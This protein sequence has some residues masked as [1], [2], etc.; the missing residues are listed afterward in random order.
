MSRCP[1]GKGYTVEEQVTDEARFGGIQI[2][3]YNAREALFPEDDPQAVERRLKELAER[4]KMRERMK[5]VRFMPGIGPSRP[6]DDL[7]LGIAAGGSIRQQIFEDQFGFQTWDEKSLVQ[8]TIRIVDT[9]TFKRITGREA[10]ATPVS[11]EHYTKAGLPWFHYAEHAPALAPSGILA[12]IRGVRQVDK[13]KGLKTAPATPAVP[14]KPEQIR[15]IAVPTREERASELRK[16][17]EASL[18]ARRYTIG[19]RQSD[20]L[21]ELVPKDKSGLMVRAEC[22]HKLSRFQEAILDA[23]EFLE[24][25]PADPASKDALILRAESHYRLGNIGGAV[26]DLIKI[27]EQDPQYLDARMLATK[28]TYKSGD[29]RP[30]IR[31]A[32]E[33]LRRSPNN[34]TAL[35]YR[36]DAF[37]RLGKV[38][39][40]IHDLERVASLVPNSKQAS[41]AAELL[42]KLRTPAEP[43]MSEAA[44]KELY[45]DFV[46]ERAE[47]LNHQR[48][49]SQKA[50]VEIGFEQAMQ[51]WTEKHRAQWYSRR[52]KNQR[53]T[54]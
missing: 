52:K 13:L 46:A 27:E 54:E 43:E 20:L 2:G 5:G 22:N 41:H 19:K 3:V 7:E 36:G 1:L 21:L 49:L 40:A 29:Y 11:A 16:S 4:E 15:E 50:G 30:T 48:A 38:R 37:F 44:R 17:C 53:G 14:I 39:H 32:N 42:K 18:R 10:P 23:S 26:M 25:T 31:N 35:L 24:I 28:I 33:V 45:D 8:L 47:I 6:E 34:A 12:R 9:A 51:D